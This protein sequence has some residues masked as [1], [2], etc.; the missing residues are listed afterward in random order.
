M[1][2]RT[3][4]TAKTTKTARSG[5]STSTASTTPTTGRTITTPT[6]RTCTTTHEANRAHARR[7]VRARAGPGA[8]SSPRYD[9]PTTWLMAPARKGSTRMLRRVAPQLTNWSVTGCSVPA[10]ATDGSLRASK[11]PAPPRTLRWAKAASSWRGTTNTATIVK[12]VRALAF[13]SLKAPSRMSPTVMGW[14]GSGPVRRPPPFG[15]GG[16]GGPHPHPGGGA[17][18][19]SGQADQRIAVIQVPK[20]GVGVGAAG[21]RRG[22]RRG[23][24]RGAGPPPRRA[25]P[26]EDGT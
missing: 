26:R 8:S 24:P 25:R 22:R 3:V 11:M 15:F 23:A 21:R 1:P 13:R 4:T 6:S 12:I 5:P 14:S 2:A 18:T 16:S 10:S 19:A 20:R 7:A 9:A 17:P